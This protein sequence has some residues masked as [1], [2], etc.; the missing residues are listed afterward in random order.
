MFPIK[1]WLH[2]SPVALITTLLLLA[3]VSPGASAQERTDSVRVFFPTGKSVFDPSFHGNGDAVDAF[4]QKVQEGEEDT[5]TKLVVEYI[6][7]N[8]SSSP[9]GSPELNERLSRSRQQS[10]LDYIGKKL[11]FV[12][13]ETYHSTG[14]IDWDMLRRLVMEDA[15]MPQAYRDD[16]LGK[17]DSGKPESIAELNGTQAW[18]YLM[19]N[20]FPQMRTTLVVFVRQVQAMELELPDFADLLS[21]DPAPSE[22]FVYPYYPPLST[23]YSVSQVNKRPETRDI[24]V[25]L[26]M[27]TLPALVLNGGIEIQ[28]LA[29][30]SVNV[31]LYYCGVNWFAE[32]IKFR[33]L[34]VQPEVRYWFRRDLHGL[35]LGAHASFGW[36]NVAWGGDYRYQDHAQKSPSLGG[37]LGV[38]YKTTLGRNNQSRWG[39]EMGIGGGV[40]PLHYDMYY[41]V[42][43]GRLAGEDKHTYWGVDQAFISLTYRIGQ[44]K[45]KQK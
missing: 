37:G 11:K 28:P 17:L 32:N 25:K 27:L 36:Y 24:V 40:L 34:A 29:H 7:V 10:V 3:A 30:F 43:N 22:A 39:L 15:A 38:G 44:L 35:F 18:K 19:D 16:V 5:A 4:I 13:G 31:P 33:V 21:T 12:A 1:A 41:N 45:L 14:A 9:E 6:T 2:R 8:S 42:H 26:N 20:V 23:S